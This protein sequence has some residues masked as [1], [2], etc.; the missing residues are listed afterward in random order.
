MVMLVVAGC[1]A[2]EPSENPDQA[3]ALPAFPEAQ[4]PFGFDPPRDAS[5]PPDAT[6]TPPPDGSPPIDAPPSTP[7]PD[8]A[9][10]CGAQPVTLDDWEDCYRKRL[11]DA[12][13]GCSEANPFLD[14][15]ECIT[16]VDDLTSGHFDAE[17]RERNR[18][19][20]QGRASVNGIRFAQ[21]L[22][23][24][25]HELCNVNGLNGLACATR[26]DG[27]VD[28][29]ASCNNDIDCRSPGAACAASCNSAD[30]C[31]LGTCQPRR[32]LDQTCS[33]SS[34][35]EP[36][37]ECHGT[38]VSGDIG[39]G[40][41]SDDDCDPGAFC[42]GTRCT[43]D[44]AVN[45]TCHRLTQCG[46][47]T[48]CV[49][50]SVV[51]SRPGKCL[52]ISHAGDACDSFCFGNLYCDAS[53]TCRDLPIQGESCT[54]SGSLCRGIDT[55]CNAGQCGLLRDLGSTCTGSQPC[56]PGSFCSSE[57]GTSPATCVLPGVPGQPCRK[58]EHCESFLCSGSAG[59]LG[60]C[61]AWSDTCRSGGN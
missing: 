43:A 60:V 19:V 48:T 50:L 27:T 17:R 11:C 55:F 46:G 8:L 1:R 58:P 16:R 33:F 56:R 20:E 13:V 23:D 22:L 18:A 25:S 54:A 53:G 39:T 41:T 14:V 4:G 6:T 7:P 51:D 30:A 44:L 15:Q 21:C 45:A 12:M 24:L 59:Q 40:C 28:D 49:G 42:N 38:C 37:L 47:E 2:A 5:M 52:R 29:N 34:E 9:Q 36:G 57:R 35:C 3:V 32:R 61:N 10:I 31:C 26:F